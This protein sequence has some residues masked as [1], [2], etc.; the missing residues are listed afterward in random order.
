MSDHTTTSSTLET[1]KTLAE[2]VRLRRETEPLSKSK[3]RDPTLIVTMLGLV[4]SIFGNVLQY[5]SA[6]ASEATAREQSATARGQ[7]DL[8]Q[9]KWVTER[10]QLRAQ[11]DR[12]QQTNHLT[13]VDRKRI[14]A[15][16]TQVKRDVQM[17]DDTIFEQEMFRTRFQGALELAKS[18]DR[19]GAAEAATKSIALTTQR[20]GEYTADRERAEKRR[21]E[22]EAQLNGAR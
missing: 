8:A 12:L 16:L 20:I 6:A 3:W 13:D 1:E 11:I 2:I 10:Q 4:V 15:E 5:R 14:E 7:F 19:P 17:Y 9:A 21:A 18:Q 22:L